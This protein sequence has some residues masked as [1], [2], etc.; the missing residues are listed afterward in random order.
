[1]ASI[2][3]LRAALEGDAPATG[4]W[5][6]IP[7]P[8]TAEALA[9]SGPDYVVVDEQHGAVGPEAMAAMLVAIAARGAAPLVRV[10]ANEPF[11]IGRALDLGA[12]GV[13]V[14]LVESAAEAARAVAAC[15]YAPEG[16]RSYGP[17]RAPL[18]HGS[19]DPDVLG[20]AICLVMVETRAGL[21]AVEEIAATPGLDGVYVGPSDLSLSLGVRPAPQLGHPTVRAA[22]E[23]VRAACQAAG[24]HCG[25]H[26]LAAE[27]AAEHAARGFSPVTAGTDLAFVHA[28]AARALATSR[29][30]G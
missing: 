22:L 7:S 16:S 19:A 10:A 9:A 26:C 11:A 21:E 30:R 27:E 25:V 2:D 17:L 23:R 28:G 5:A 14:P 1:M 18:A 12:A 3:Q 24:V 20:G 4:L 29:E 15:R 8:L 6:T 13:I